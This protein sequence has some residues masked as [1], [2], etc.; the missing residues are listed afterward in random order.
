MF[1]LYFILTECIKKPYDYTTFTEREVFLF[2]PLL[3]YRINT[4]PLRTIF[5]V[6]YGIIVYVFVWP[7]LLFVSSICHKT[8]FFDRLCSEGEHSFI[9]R[10]RKIVS[11]IYNLKLARKLIC[12]L[13]YIYIYPQGYILTF[14]WNNKTLTKLN[15]HRVANV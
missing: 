14:N 10:S 3:I 11:T 13:I 9:L 2:K 1:H 6:N 15:F 8:S 4:G 5:V 12:M 7:F